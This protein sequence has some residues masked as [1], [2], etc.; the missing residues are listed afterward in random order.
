V[1]QRPLTT[2]RAGERR[3]QLLDAATQLFAERDYDEVSVDEIAEA[4]GVSHGLIFQYFG[5]KKDL[6]VTAMGPLI[7]RFRWRIAPDLELPP[8][9]RLESSIRSW[10]ALMS[11][12]QRSYR[13]LMTKAIGFDGIRDELAR[14]H[15]GAVERIALQIGVDPDRPEVQVGLRA[16]IGF[17]ETAML[18][19]L[20][21]GGPDL[22]VLVEI[23]SEAFFATARA[24][25]QAGELSG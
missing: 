6:Y 10:A 22:D 14:M 18:A 13:S 11:E 4:A 12:H 16:W 7:E 3:R 21:T 24:L 8:R 2:K 15:A 19:W 1:A 20:D 23:I 5:T 25:L 17:M 9:E